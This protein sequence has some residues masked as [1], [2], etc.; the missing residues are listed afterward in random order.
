[1]VARQDPRGG[2]VGARPNRQNGFAV[3]CFACGRRNC[4]GEELCPARDRICHFCRAIGHYEVIC[5]KRLALLQSRDESLIPSRPASPVI[6][7]ES[8]SP[9][10]PNAVSQ[11]DQMDLS[12]TPEESSW[13]FGDLRSLLRFPFS[14]LPRSF[15]PESLEACW[16]QSD[17]MARVSDDSFIIC[18]W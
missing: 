3:L 5:A 15:L 1:M 11:E 16:P 13:Q 17:L 8:Q 6:P 4:L 18:D 9:L 12:L 2:Y 7:V 14:L 10:A